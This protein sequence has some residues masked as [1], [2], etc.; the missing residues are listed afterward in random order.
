MYCNNFDSELSS[1][2]AKADQTTKAETN[3]RY[4]LITLLITGIFTI[5]F[6]NTEAQAPAFSQY[7]AASLFLNPAL[8]GE[9]GDWTFGLNH[10]SRIDNNVYPYAL[11]QFSMVVPL[12]MSRYRHNKKFFRNGYI[13]GLGLTVYNEASGYH[14]ELQTSGFLG[15]FAYSTQLSASH[16]LSFSLQMGY[17]LRNLDYQ[18]LQ[19][20][21]Q[22]DPSAGYNG[23]LAPSVNLAN[24]Q[25]GFPVINS[26]VIWQYIP[27]FNTS[28]FK[29]FAG[30]AVSGLNR[31]NESLFDNERREIPLLWKW[32]GGVVYQLNERL[33][34]LPNYLIMLQNGETQLNAGTYFSFR[35]SDKPRQRHTLQIG[36]WYRLKDAM[37]A[38][39][40][41][42]INSFGLAVSYD[43]NAS[44]FQYY[45]TGEGTVEVSLFYRIVHDKMRVR[46]ISHPLM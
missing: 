17:I 41:Y 25:N 23:N 9:E 29:A 5:K 43:F 35:L 19:W 14:S 22:Y 39:I 27:H 31:P 44:S 26:G 38:A 10:R 15:T 7:Y 16:F 45:N 40:G 30:F 18:H 3:M 32:H 37:I 42:E 20:G 11:S 46:N 28:G 4:F 24:G 1:F 21:S 6:G 36:G 33:G 8:A 13:G 2:S 12:R 34:I